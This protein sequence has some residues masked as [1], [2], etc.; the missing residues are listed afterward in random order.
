MITIT[1]RQLRELIKRELA[2][3]KR[4]KTQHHIIYE[5]RADDFN[6]RFKNKGIDEEEILDIFE[7]YGHK[8]HAAIR[9]VRKKYPNLTNQDI[10]DLIGRYATTPFKN[11][12]LRE[13]KTSI[14]VDLNFKGTTRGANLK[15]LKA[16]GIYGLGRVF[17]I[18]DIDYVELS[19]LIRADADFSTSGD[20]KVELSWHLYDEVTCTVIEIWNYKNGPKYRG[21]ANKTD[22]EY[23]DLLREIPY[24]SVGTNNLAV[25]KAYFKS[26]GIKVVD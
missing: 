13:G 3:A 2:Y 21:I 15:Q 14:T 10:D 6:N 5:N 22:D 17:G 16:M 4:V 20:L 19:N 18:E 24:F 7:K 1:N 25:A 9:V 23:E 8:I 11:K 12:K 26:L